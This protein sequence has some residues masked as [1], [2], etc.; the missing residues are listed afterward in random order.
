MK[1]LLTR[2]PT[3]AALI[4]FAFATIR[5]LP[6]LPFSLLV[7]AIA[8]LAARELLRLTNPTTRSLPLVLANGLLVAAAFTFPQL[9]MREM[10]AAVV[11]LNGLFFL[12]AVRRSELLPAFVRDFGIHLATAFYIYLPLYFLYDL[13]RPDPNLLFF[14]ILVIA[15]GDSGAYF[16]GVAIGRHKIYPVASPKKSLEGLIAAVL[17]A[18]PAGWLS[19]QIFPPQKISPAPLTVI[20]SAAAIGLVSQLSDPVESLFKRAAGAKDSGTLLPGHGGVLD[21]VDS[22][23][24]CAPLLAALVNYLW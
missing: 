21:R 6:D 12:F 7:Y 2:L 20:L 16:V 13:G 8:S 11:A 4:L 5:Y 17:T 9:P 18:A 22:Y 1:D 10:L 24:F 14:L 19:L 23:I 15:I 3:T